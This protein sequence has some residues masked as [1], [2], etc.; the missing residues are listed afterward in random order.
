VQWRVTAKSPDVI[1]R[2]RETTC[3]LTD[4]AISTDRNATHTREQK[5]R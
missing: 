5:R 2:E 3:K 1:I 4:M